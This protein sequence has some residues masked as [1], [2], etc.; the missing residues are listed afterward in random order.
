[1]KAVD[2]AAITVAGCALMA[3]AGAGV[4]H[5]AAHSAA[6]LVKAD[7]VA[8]STLHSSP[9]R[10]AVPAAS[11]PGPAALP[12]TAPAS[13]PAGSPEYATQWRLDGAEGAE[14]LIR[15]WGPGGGC[16][17]LDHVA[18]AETAT[19]VT[20]G[21]YDYQGHH[22]GTAA[23]SAVLTSVKRAVKLAAPLG[24]RKLVHLALPPT[25]APLS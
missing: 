18:V 6:A 7:P 2:R 17:V 5:A 16:T 14:L 15:V 22:G 19:T 23:C 1:M 11:P 8:T 25:P 9:L 12:P 13:R 24:N 10:S 21:A 4:A 3:A 20:I